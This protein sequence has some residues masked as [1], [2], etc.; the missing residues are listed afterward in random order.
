MAEPTKAAVEAAEKALD[1]IA[2][3][4]EATEALG[5]VKS[6][7]D[8]AG[9]LAGLAGP[10]FALV[11]AVIGLI[12]AFLPDKEFEA[13]M[14]QF[15][16]LH[17]E[18][19]H[20]RDD[21]K[22]LEKTIKWE[23]TKLQYAEVVSRIELAMEFTKYIGQSKDDETKRKDYQ[24]R[25]EELC[26]DESVLLAIQTLI[27]GLTGRGEFRNDILQSFY[28]HSWGD[29]PKLARLGGRL[30]QLVCGGL[31]A[32][33]TYETLKRGKGAAQE[34]ADMFQGDLDKINISIRTAI[35]LCTK[36]FKINMEHDVEKVL[37][38]NHS[39]KNTLIIHALSGVLSEKYDWLRLYCMVSDNKGIDENTL[40]GSWIGKLNYFDKCAV[41]FY[42]DAEPSGKY[43]G[44]KEEVDGIVRS[45]A[46]QDNARH[47]F[48]YITDEL[49]KRGIG[50]WGIACV[51]RLV[52]LEGQSSG[53]VYTWENGKHLT[54]CV[55]LK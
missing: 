25:L 26:G 27:N 35:D 51:K 52:G 40:G 24:E 14:H 45:I 48:D 23:A 31:M 54:M 49:K 47:A 7:L 11:G 34:V 1:L 43:A 3:L 17:Q 9:E 53:A 4:S 13:I 38:E 41:A 15:E 36:N 44:R 28:E 33:M 10:V 5:A 37:E 6:L 16:L 39:G 21:I 18:I 55:L 8:A 12:Q 32:Q 50:W 22:E 19:Q 42:V 46:G 20:V 29:R 2:S 30:V